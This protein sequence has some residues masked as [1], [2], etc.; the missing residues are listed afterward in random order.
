MLIVSGKLAAIV[1][2]EAPAGVAERLDLKW[3]T[4]Q[5]IDCGCR[6]GCEHETQR[7]DEATRAFARVCNRRACPGL[8]ILSPM[9][10]ATKTIKV[11]FDSV[12]DNTGDRAVGAALLVFAASRGAEIESLNPLRPSNLEAGQPVVIGGGELIHAPGDPFYDAFRLEGP[13]ILNTVGLASGVGLEFLEQYE[14][15]SVRSSLDRSLVDSVR[16]D[17]VVVP[18]ISTDLEP[19]EPPEEL[20][21]NTVLAHVHSN[22][23]HHIPTIAGVLE[24]LSGSYEIK[25]ISLTPYAGD[26]ATMLRLGATMSNPPVVVDRAAG[27]RQKIAVISKAKLL[28]CASLHGAIFAHANNVPFVVYAQPPKVRAF[29]EDRGLE[30]LGFTDEASLRLALEKALSGSLD[31]SHS[32]EQDK[33]RLA[34]HKERLAELLHLPPP[35]KRKGGISID[36]KKLYHT[37]EAARFDAVALNQAYREMEALALKTASLAHLQKELAALR[38][39]A[40]FLEEELKAHREELEKWRQIAK[41]YEAD[42]DRWKERGLAAEAALTQERARNEML[43]HLNHSLAQIAEALKASAGNR[44]PLTERLIKHSKRAGKAAMARLPEKVREPSRR[45]VEKALGRPVE[46][47]SVNSTASRVPISGTAA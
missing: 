22:M 30:Y 46:L 10:G 42:R 43:G 33:K 17:A 3:I 13:H 18:C 20:S 25:W 31:F 40:A 4:A 32:I 41:D 38:E 37:T 2:S 15:V 26:R 47:P 27:P 16:P 14:Y 28:I 11:L 24:E 7:W 35:K 1:Q 12:H 23:A 5:D 36:P 29:L 9:A 39:H 8:Y 45:L 21:P 6:A 44:H 34:E 19:S